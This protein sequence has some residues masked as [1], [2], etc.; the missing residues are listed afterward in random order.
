MPRRSLSALERVLIWE[1]D[2]GICG[3]CRDPVTLATLHIDHIL[4]V[5]DGGETSA[6][7]LRATHGRCNLK[8]R[9]G[10]ALG[11]RP[12]IGPK[13][14]FRIPDATYERL[15]VI[16]AGNASKGLRDLDEAYGAA[17]VRKKRQDPQE[18]K[19]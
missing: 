3:V 6:G 18:E 16:G 17:M 11:G 5:V 14:E 7:N 13:R 9:E 15:K 10:R 8:R 19:K 12:S 4:A 2:G 1:R